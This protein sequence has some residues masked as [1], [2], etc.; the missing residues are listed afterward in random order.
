MGTG[1]SGGDFL[2]RAELS[3]CGAR[4][5]LQQ[6]PLP[7]PFSESFPGQVSWLGA[8][9]GARRHKPTPGPRRDKSGQTQIAKAQLQFLFPVGKEL[10]KVTFF[11]FF[12]KFSA[13]NFPRTADPSC[14]RSRGGAAGARCGITG[15]SSRAGAVGKPRCS[16]GERPPGTCVCRSMGS[17]RAPASGNGQT[18]MCFKRE[19]SRLSYH[20]KPSPMERCFPTAPGQRGPAHR[21]LP[22]PS[23]YIIGHF[24]GYW[25]AGWLPGLLF[26]RSLCSVGGFFSVPQRHTQLTGWFQTCPC[27]S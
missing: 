22:R 4:V 11:F 10:A 13:C 27:P 17:T 15:L 3:R 20:W 24:A 18:L 9:S 5:E 14:D 2:L 23:E 19:G 21:C 12:F 1:R 16:G 25:P 8:R 6:P 7:P 26:D